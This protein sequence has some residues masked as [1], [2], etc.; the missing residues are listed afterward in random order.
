MLFRSPKNDKISD[1]LFSLDHDF[2]FD[3]MSGSTCDPV[4]ETES[5][6]VSTIAR[7]KNRLQYRELC[8]ANEHIITVI[9][10]GYRIPFRTLPEDFVLKNNR[11]ALDNGVFVESEIDKL[12]A[13]DCISQVDTRPKCVNPLTVAFNRNGKPRLVLD[14]RDL[15]PHLIQFKFKYED[16]SIAKQIFQKGDFLFTFDLNNE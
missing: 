15:N 12:V 11:S 2:E 4:V 3:C 5:G 6:M 7:L 9:E 14:C 8:N 13:K 16:V 1:V 10:K